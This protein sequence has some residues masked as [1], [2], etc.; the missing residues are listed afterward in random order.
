MYNFAKKKK[1]DGAKPPPPHPPVPMPM[2]YH[3]LNIFVLKVLM[4]FCI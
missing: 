3:D 2:I 4:I 1:S